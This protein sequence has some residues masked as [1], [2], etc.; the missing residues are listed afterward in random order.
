MR[1]TIVLLLLFVCST[2]QAEIRIRPGHWA[3]PVIGSGLDNFYLVDD[4]V[5][6]SEQP[7]SKAF[8]D[9]AQFGITDILNLRQFHSD[10]DEAENTDLNLHRVEMNAGSV[11]EEQ[12]VESLKIIKNRKKAIVVHCWHGSDRTGAVLAAYRII[13]NNWSKTQA[14][15]EMKNGGFGYHS[16]IYPSLVKLI[17]NLGIPTIKQKL[18]L[19][20]EN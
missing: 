11:T 5:Y 15:D 3:V 20:T 1:K 7:D 12:I 13:F 18:G 4:G 19:S 9:L 10:T 2:A 8:H 17:E 6:R 16:T 14:V